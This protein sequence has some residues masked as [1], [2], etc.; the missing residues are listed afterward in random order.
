MAVVGMGRTK[1]RHASPEIA[2]ATIITHDDHAD[3]GLTLVAIAHASATRGHHEANVATNAAPDHTIRAV[4]V[5]R[6]KVIG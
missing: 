1:P 6:G 4:E 3:D 2:V 5:N